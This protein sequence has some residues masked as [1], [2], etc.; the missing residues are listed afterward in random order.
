MQD[1]NFL[2]TEANMRRHER[3]RVYTPCSRAR[4]ARRYTFFPQLIVLDLVN[5]FPEY[6]GKCYLGRSEEITNGAWRSAN[7]RGMG[8]LSCRLGRYYF[9]ETLLRKIPARYRPS[10]LCLIIRKRR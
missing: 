1:A 10:S 7:N 9:R 3:D 2:L 4:Q 8:M 6:A 5:T